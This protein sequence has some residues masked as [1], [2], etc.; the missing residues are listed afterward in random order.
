LSEEESDAI[1][2]RYHVPAATAVLHEYA[3]ANFHRDAPTKVDFRR[4]GRAPLLFIAFGED[5][6]MPPKLVG[7]TE[8]KYDDSVSITEFKEF[9]GRPRF[10]GAPGWEEVADHALT[11]A[12]EHAHPASA[13]DD[14]PATTA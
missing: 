1:Y 3:F 7:H 11:W 4:D 13:R 5:H 9:P 6:V 12:V 8:E 2:R 14:S 10:P